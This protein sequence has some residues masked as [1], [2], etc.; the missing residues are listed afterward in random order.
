MKTIF[1]LPP[2]LVIILVSLIF[3]DLANA[4]QK[5]QRGP[6]V[7]KFLVEKYDADNNGKLSKEEYDR[8]EEI[9]ARFDTDKDGELTAKDWSGQTSN[10]RRRG[11]GRKSEGTAA[12]AVGDIAPDFLLT[13]IQD[14]NKEV[15][16]SSFAGSKPVAL[17]FGSCT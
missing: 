15:Q 11:R 3:G 9:F 14:E 13:H 10:R 12:P 16:L 5:R 17:I 6:D 1:R 4:Q 8:S 2:P 7:F